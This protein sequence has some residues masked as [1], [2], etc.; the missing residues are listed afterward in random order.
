ML[1]RA[2]AV[3]VLLLGWAA[4]AGAQEVKGWLVG[5]KCALAGKV[6]ECFLENA[7][8]MVLFTGEGEFYRIDLDGVDA[9]ELDKA[10]GKEVAVEG[11]MAENRIKVRQIK[12]V[13]PVGNQEF[14]KGC[15]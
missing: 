9:I 6:G 3:A 14:F 7:Y 4:G 13:E 10:F 2:V 5:E 15:L 1:T 8:P 12:V 11:E